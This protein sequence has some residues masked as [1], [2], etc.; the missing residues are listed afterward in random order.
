MGVGHAHRPVGVDVIAEISDIDG[1][2]VRGAIV[3]A[4]LCG[5][6]IVGSLV[7]DVVRLVRGAFDTRTVMGAVARYLVV[8]AV[9][10]P[11]IGATGTA[12]AATCDVIEDDDESPPWVTPLVAGVTALGVV[13]GRERWRRE[14]SVV[15]M[16]SDDDLKSEEFPVI[17][18]TVVPTCVPVHEFMACVL[19]PVQ[20][21]TEDGER[22]RFA[23][24]RSEELV[25]WLAMHPARRF[26]SLARN[27]MWI[28]SVKD[29]TFANVTSEA[30][31]ALHEAA[32]DG[33]WLSVTL[34]DA[35]P[36]TGVVTDIEVLKKCLDHA[37]RWPEDDG[38]E[39]L[40][41]GLA[42][43]RGT[44]FSGATY[45]W[46]DATGLSTDAAML[47]VRSAMLLAEMCADAGDDEGVYW[48]TA[49]GL[50]A[51]PGHESLIAVR[52]RAHAR[53]GDRAGLATEWRSYL[54]FLATDPWSNAH[55]SPDMLRMWEEVGGT[56]S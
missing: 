53:R 8:G 55:P 37:R 38:I 2:I 49:Q 32:G 9:A 17:V 45:S 4:V 26:R 1:L 39:T 43:V 48:A 24:A 18:R 35:L 40:R 44:P 22:V 46:N 10:A 25:V 27:D 33:E 50:L 13:V 42:L 30:R 14:P 12:R 23:R 21:V 34:T 41:F 11:V 19:G 36:L 47:V 15:E 51:L 7:Y 29:S 5:V 20:V 3:L 28:E 6:W 31:R 52:L 54:R 16:L 56:E